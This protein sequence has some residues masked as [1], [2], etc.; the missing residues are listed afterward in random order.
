MVLED[1]PV[2]QMYPSFDSLNI[3]GLCPWRINK[4]VLDLHPAPPKFEP[5]MSKADKVKITRER[6]LN[7]RRRAEMYSLWCD[8]LYKLS[9]ANHF[10]DRVFWFPHNM[11]FRGRVYPC[12]PHFNHLGSD[13]VRGILLFAR[14]EP[15]GEKGLDWL[16]IHLVN[17]TGLKKREPCV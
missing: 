9:I 1:T 3:L 13:V 12:P 7:K 8:A 15:L 17:L 10:R 11:D 16:K 5:G 2:Q 4:P 14:G 6:L